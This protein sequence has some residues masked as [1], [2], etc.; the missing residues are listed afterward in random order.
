MNLHHF[1]EELPSANLFQPIK[2]F[3]GRTSGPHSSEWERTRQSMD[4]VPN[5]CDLNP[6]PC[7]PFVIN[8]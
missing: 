6:S 7:H 1:L 8:K 3:R 2:G 5:G 4:F